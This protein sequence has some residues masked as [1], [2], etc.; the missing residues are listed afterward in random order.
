VDE[1]QVR[2]ATILQ[3]KRLSIQTL[4]CSVFWLILMTWFWRP[5]P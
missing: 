2:N 3:I 4:W 5:E 1:F